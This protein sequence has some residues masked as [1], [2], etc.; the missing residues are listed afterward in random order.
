[1]ASFQERRLALHTAL[2]TIMGTNH[3]YY[4]PPP[5]ILMT[6]PC[7][8]YEPE[9]FVSQSADNTK[10][11][12]SRTYKVTVVDRNPDST[13]ADAVGAM[14]NSKFNRWYAS[15]QL[16]HFVFTITI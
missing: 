2:Q 10:Y 11:L 12:Q 13:Y 16:N 9:A 8:R 14:R 1:M 6:Y 3:V 7:I 4:Q 5:D 15:D